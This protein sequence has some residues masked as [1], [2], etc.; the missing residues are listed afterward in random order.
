MNEGLNKNLVRMLKRMGFTGKELNRMYL[1]LVSFPLPLAT[2]IL[3][4][5]RKY[6][7]PRMPKS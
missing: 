1:L 4:Q 6:R 7:V 3:D 2:F 5:A